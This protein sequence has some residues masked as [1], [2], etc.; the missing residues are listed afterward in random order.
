MMRRPRRCG[1]EKNLSELH[2]RYLYFSIVFACW[3][4]CICM[5]LMHLYFYGVFAFF[6][7]GQKLVKTLQPV[8][9]LVLYLHIDVFLENN[10]SI[11]IIIIG[12][13]IIIE[14]YF[15]GNNKG[16]GCCG[17]LASFLAWIWAD[18]KMRHLVVPYVS[19]YPN[20]YKSKYP[21]IQVYKYS[22]NQW[23]K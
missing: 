17:G 14:L 7:R 6:A 10:A 20:I 4:I 8:V 13:I 11:I 15:Q 2:S 23:L 18:F 21:A 5:M 22:K 16:L 19:K 3:C 12:I 9:V 1:A